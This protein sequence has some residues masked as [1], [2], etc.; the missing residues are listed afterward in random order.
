MSNNTKRSDYSR[1]K[2]GICLNDECEM[3]KKRVVQEIPLRKDFVCQN[4]DCGRELKECP[5]PSP[6]KK[7]WIYIVVALLVVGA[8]VGCILAFSGKKEQAVK[9]E[10]IKEVILEQDSTEVV[11]AETELVEEVVLEQDS[12]EVV[13]LEPELEEEVVSEEKPTEELTPKPSEE[14]TQKEESA[15]AVTTEVKPKKDATPKSSSSSTYGTLQ[16][17]YGTYTGD[18]VNGYPHGKGRLKYSVRRQVNKNDLKA[19]MAEPGDYVVGTFFNGFFIQGD[20][21]NAEGEL[22]KSFNVGIG[23]ESS[24]ES[25]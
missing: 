6:P 15:K 5:P 13:A 11:T 20:L 10:P 1:V 22:Q 7:T 17:S 8:I 19:R 16:L 3:C 9:P 21:Y 14:V 4:P 12:T 18:I 2:Y 25:K 23:P 24:Y